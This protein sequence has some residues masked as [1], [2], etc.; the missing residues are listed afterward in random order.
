M[1]KKNK[2]RIR[3]QPE[4]VEVSSFDIFGTLLGRKE[5]DPLLR[6]QAAYATLDPRGREVE[7]LSRLR[8]A[9]EHQAS[10][11]H[12]P[13]RYSL[14]DIYGEMDR[15]YHG[16]PGWSSTA[17]AA[18]LAMEREQC[19]AIHQGKNLLN[20]AQKSTAILY[21]TDMYL[22]PSFIQELLIRN[23]LW[24]EGARL[25]VSHTEGCA[26]HSGLFKK[27]L[28]ELKVPPSAMV[29]VGDSWGADVLAPRK[30][31]IRARYFRGA[32]PSRYESRLTAERAP[33]AAQ[34]FRFARLGTFAQRDG[35]SRV[36][37]ETACNVIAPLFIP[38]VQWIAR[39]AMEKN[40]QR[41]YFVS[42][43]GLIFKKIYDI[44]KLDRADWP[45]S[46]YLYGSRQAWSCVRAAEFRE[47]DLDFFLFEK[48]KVSFFQV[49]R[50]IGF[51]EDEIAKLALPAGF[52]QRLRRPAERAELEK[53]KHLLMEPAWVAGIRAHGE[54]R[55]AAAV[56]YLRQEGLFDQSGYGLVDLGWGGNLQSYLDRMLRPMSIPVGFYFH[57]TQ[58]TDL[59]ETGRALGWLS[60]L[61]LHG[62]DAA[63]GRAALEIFCSANHGMAI[64]YHRESA[65]WEPILGPL[66]AGGPERQLAPT[67]HA[68]LQVCAKSWVQRPAIVA[69]QENL[70]EPAIENFKRFMLAPDLAEAE[71][72]GEN[73]LTSRQEGGDA[74]VYGPAY[75]IR[76]A[77]KSFRKRFGPRETYW[78]GGIVRRS[79]GI[80]KILVS[81]RFNMARGKSALLSRLGW[82]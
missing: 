57:L 42:R 54:K 78:P 13:D 18:E 8:L 31:G 3:C 61:P 22:P 40:L 15:Q 55:A 25:F 41:L 34:V 56:G 63:A 51:S 27:I 17:C 37:W 14:A 80:A 65:V 68:A 38:Y 1:I 6:F 11:Q 9:A 58:K 30:L 81:L 2:A 44:L 23:D 39:R 79:K 29:H 12:G 5:T 82:D 47:K 24:V 7:E 75:S 21:V 10:R 19:F 43:D 48:S 26:K 4:T 53:L 59:T 50:R 33:A 36:A 76:M 49:F 77:C 52:A 16:A 69:N 62:W 46:R 67:H 28:Q 70:E 45:E 64:G 35:T 72:Y 32:A 66:D 71:T 73:Y 60:R 74:D 20:E